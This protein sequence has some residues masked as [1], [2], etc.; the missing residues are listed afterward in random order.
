M[1]AHAQNLPPPNRWNRKKWTELM[2][3]LPTP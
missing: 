1:A 3:S 2:E